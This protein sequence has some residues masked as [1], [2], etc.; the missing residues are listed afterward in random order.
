MSKVFRLQH[1]SELK[2]VVL[3]AIKRDNSVFSLPK[4]K[5]DWRKL[6][7]II[8]IYEHKLKMVEVGLLGN[9]EQTSHVIWTEDGFKQIPERLNRNVSCIPGIRVTLKTG[10]V[11]YYEL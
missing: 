8:A 2:Y 10:R 3:D 4:K 6:G 5:F 7:E 9:F 11:E 1:I